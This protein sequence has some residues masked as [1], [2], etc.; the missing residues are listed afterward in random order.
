M[1]LLGPKRLHVQNGFHCIPIC[2]SPLN[3][4]HSGRQLTL[5]PRAPCPPFCHPF[6]TPPLQDLSYYRTVE[7][8]LKAV[9]AGGRYTPLSE[10]IVTS[11]KQQGIP[12]SQWEPLAPQDQPRNQA[13]NPGT[14]LQQ[15]SA[16][17]S[18]V[19][20]A[21]EGG[22]VGS[23][24]RPSTPAA[25]AAA[26]HLRM[27]LEM[28]CGCSVT[29]AMLS[30]PITAQSAAA[31]VAAAE[32]A[33]AAASSS[34]AAAA[35]GSDGSSS[36]QDTAVAAAAAAAAS[37]AAAVAPVSAQSSSSPGAAAT[38]AAGGAAAA[39]TAGT[40]GSSSPVAAKLGGQEA[41]WLYI[42]HL[43]WCRCGGGTK[44]DAYTML[45]TCKGSK[46]GFARYSPGFNMCLTPAT[47]RSNDAVID[48][49][50]LH[51]SAVAAL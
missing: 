30:D 35:A 26:Q 3:R 18:G 25:A 16:S 14:S 33:A 13:L 1:L 51:S 49:S 5:C 44:L 29:E 43:G 31:Q 27:A 36:S 45:K 46:H 8:L 2:A 38:A 39:A 12:G 40:A 7:V 23:G 6:R 10:Q 50:S 37:A 28:L 21:S 34:T 9:H 20:A 42:N 47:A 22:S 15:G 4:T 19:L 32:A 24:S 41:M 11:L 17:G 48:V